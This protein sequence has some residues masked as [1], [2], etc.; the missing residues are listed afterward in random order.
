[1]PA[2]RSV[3]PAAARGAPPLRAPAALRPRPLDVGVELAAHAGERVG[4][5]ARQRRQEAE[6]EALRLEIGI[7]RERVLAVDLGVGGE[8]AA[9]LLPS[10]HRPPHLPPLPLRT[11]LP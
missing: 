8:R 1:A 9:L 4:R 2:A 7:G 5:A 6:V 10:L 11:P 3:E